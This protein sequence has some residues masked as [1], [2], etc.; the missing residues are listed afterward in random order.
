MV[1]TT[2]LTVRLPEQLH[3]TLTRESDTSGD[4]LNAVIVNRLERSLGIAYVP[5]QEALADRLSALEV[6]VSKMEAER[7][8]SPETD[9]G[10]EES[11]SLRLLKKPL[12]SE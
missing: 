7:D 12:R 8:L 1:K 6:R 10:E 2:R 4:P 9:G 3:Q 5:T 11:A